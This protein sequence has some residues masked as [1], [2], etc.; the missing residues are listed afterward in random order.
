ML[1]ID[2]NRIL[3]VFANLLDNALKF[4]SPG[5]RI[6]VAAEAVAAG[7]SFAVANSGEALPSDILHAM[8]QTV[9]AGGAGRSS[10]SG[11]RSCDLPLDRGGARRHDLG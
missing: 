4:T 6:L 1:H 10:W 8:F 9:L 5:G 2:D 7:V 3:R 11:S